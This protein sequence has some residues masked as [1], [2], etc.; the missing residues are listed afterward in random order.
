ME[1]LIKNLYLILYYGF[2]RFLPHSNAPY[3]V[4]SKRMRYVLCKKLFKSIGDNVNVERLAFFRNGEDIEIGENS[5]LG[6]N[7]YITNAKIGKNV[8]MGPDVLYIKN[9]H[10][11]DRLDV[12]MMEQGNTPERPLIVGDD[13]WIGAKAIFLPGV[14]IGRGAIIAAGSVVTKDVPE[15]AIVAGN[16]AIIK[17]YRK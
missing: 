16:P 3:Q 5:G 13:V 14:S 12:P 8:M 17:S 7:C 6:I 15:Y 11:F 2:A 1:K 9:K 4:V 10:C